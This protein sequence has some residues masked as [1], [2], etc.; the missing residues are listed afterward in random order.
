M[1]KQGERRKGAA[2]A[3]AKSY[4][5][6]V[7]DKTSG[8]IKAGKSANSA[9]KIVG[10]VLN[11]A[12]NE[13]LEDLVLHLL[14]NRQKIFLA[15]SMVKKPAFGAD[16]NEPSEGCALDTN[17]KREFDYELICAFCFRACPYSRVLIMCVH[18]SYPWSVRFGNTELYMFSNSELAF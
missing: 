5:T 10:N 3:T 17:R 13:A 11:A 15:H 2:K 9:D 12:Q 7:K 14:E 1:V 4:V 16:E 6:L 8:R 18:C